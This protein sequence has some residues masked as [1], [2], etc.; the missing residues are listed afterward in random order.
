MDLAIEVNNVSKSYGP[1]FGLK[2]ISLKVNKGDVFALV[3]QNG[4]GKTTL[5]K[6]ILD[7][8]RTKEGE[9]R[10][11]GVISRSEES[12]AKVGFIPEKFSFFSFYTVEGV[13]YFFANSRGIE[14]E[15]QKAVVDDAIERMSLQEVRTRRLSTFSKGQ[16]QRVGLATLLIGELDLF[17]LDEPF[18]GLD[19]I[20]IKD[21]KELIRELKNAGKTV[22]INSHILLEMENLCD[23]YAILK[24]GELV[25]SGQI[26]DFKKIGMSFEDYFTKLVVGNS[27]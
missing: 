7:L 3:G 4:A 27:K 13:L 9:I 10:L 16:V 8:L 5:V 18:S 21:L 22:F 11:D 19:P 25:G 1:H 6:L 12:R 20:G 2:N 14:K 24:N 26:Q 23:S 17:I 15:K